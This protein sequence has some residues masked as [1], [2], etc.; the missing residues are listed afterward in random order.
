MDFK[1]GNKM[2][3]LEICKLG[4]DIGEEVTQLI[5]NKHGRLSTCSLNTIW[6]HFIGAAYVKGTLK[7]TS[8]LRLTCAITSLQVYKP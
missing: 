2:N 3:L 5:Q 1:N 7:Y 4:S 6:T 8:D